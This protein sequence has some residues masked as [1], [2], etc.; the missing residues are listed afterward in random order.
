MVIYSYVILYIMT[1]R[2][3]K[4]QVYECSKCGRQFDSK[5]DVNAHFDEVHEFADK[6]LGSYI[7]SNDEKYI[8]KVVDTSFTKSNNLFIEVFTIGQPRWNIFGDVRNSYV[9]RYAITLKEF[10]RDFKIVPVEVIW[11]ILNKRFIREGYES[12]KANSTIKTDFRE[13]FSGVYREKGDD[14]GN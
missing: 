7:I 10:E 3:V 12:L 1:D 2:F 14:D 8:G 9:M 5:E 4:K 13:I 11:E 6:Y